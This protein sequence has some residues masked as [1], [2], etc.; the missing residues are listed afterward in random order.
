VVHW[1][2]NT[3][4]IHLF[5]LKTKIHGKTTVFKTSSQHKQDKAYITCLNNFYGHQVVCLL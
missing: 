3:M 1:A 4:H 2:D 5:Y